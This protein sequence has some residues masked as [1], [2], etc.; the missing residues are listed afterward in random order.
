MGNEG[1]G[2]A[3]DSQVFHPMFDS[4]TLGRGWLCKGGSTRASR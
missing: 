4:R 1:T 3:D 2:D